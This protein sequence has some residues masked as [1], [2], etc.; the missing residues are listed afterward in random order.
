M[1]ANT[2]TISF[3]L[4]GIF[5]LI[6]V[7]AMFISFY[8]IKKGNIAMEKLDKMIELFKYV[9]VSTAMATVTLVV[10]DLFK[11]REQDVKELE[12]F[13]KYV[14]DVKKVD[15]IQERLQLSKYLSIV[16]PSGEMKKSWEKYYKTV[17]DEYQ[18][19]I[20]LKSELRSIDTI[21]NPTEEQILKTEKT[22][23]AINMY[24][25]PLASNNVSTRRPTVYIQY[26]NK[27]NKNQISELRKKFEENSWNAPGIEFTEKGCDNSIRYFHEEDRTL[28]NEANTLL[29]NKYS[30]KKSSFTAPKGQIEIWAK[31]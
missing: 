16:A 10:A 5:I 28:A 8:Q 12:Y 15:G 25:K 13:D 14:E 20:K 27:E 26:C 7:I 18:E 4:Y 2:G 29:G 22:K 21:S 9:I 30:I 24:E 17:E 19:Y 6:T 1:L 11:E 31:E 3:L 23:E